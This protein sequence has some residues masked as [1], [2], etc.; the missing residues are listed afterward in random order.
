VDSRNSFCEPHYVM[1]LE[2]LVL[3]NV[4]SAERIIYPIFSRFN[5]KWRTCTRPFY[6]SSLTS[7][8]PDSG[9]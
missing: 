2:E 7:P 4:A 9:D 3:I 8:S 5:Q 6:T 1:P